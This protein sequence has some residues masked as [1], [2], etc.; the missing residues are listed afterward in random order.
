MA[1]CAHNPPPPNTQHTGIVTAAS[2]GSTFACFVLLWRPHV[3]LLG[4]LLGVHAFTKLLAALL[5]LAESGLPIVLIFKHRM[6]RLGERLFDTTLQLKL[7]A[8]AAPAGPAGA[9]GTRAGRCGSSLAPL[10]A[11]DREALA[12]ALTKR[13]EAAA[14]AGRV[15][16]K[17][18]LLGSLLAGAFSLGVRLLLRPRPNEG[19]LMR[20][21]R[22]FATLG[23]AALVPGAALLLPLAVYRDSGA[24]VASLLS[25]YLQQK[26][27]AEI[28]RAHV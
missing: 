28:G 13:R 14:A 4:R 20:K 21:G 10:P 11:A 6:D 23:V 3:A 27:V 5:I 25:R 12:A 17:R 8:A 26:G 18:S 1:S 19:V 15:S 24:E 2:C 22:D 9:A 16:A 7:G